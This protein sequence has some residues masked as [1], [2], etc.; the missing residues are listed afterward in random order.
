MGSQL[1]SDSVVGA[2]MAVPATAMIVT[3]HIWLGAAIVVSVVAAG[4]VS[5]RIRL[6]AEAAEQQGYL[7]YAH[8]ATSLG[9]DP[10]PVIKAMRGSDEDLD[11]DDGTPPVHL[12][13]R[14]RT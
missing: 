13:P 14:R 11:G 10:A 3:G 2:I 12:P 9:A 4:V 7:S 6:R 1:G 8:T 5:A